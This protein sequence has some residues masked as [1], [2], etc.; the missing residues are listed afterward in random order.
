[1]QRA[2]PWR[3]LPAFPEHDPAVRLAAFNRV[4]TDSVDEAAEQSDGSSARTT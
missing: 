4:S 1:M 2:G 3:G